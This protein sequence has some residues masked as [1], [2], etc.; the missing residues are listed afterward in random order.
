MLVGVVGVPFKERRQFY[1]NDT[2]GARL[3]FC[4]YDL[5]I[6]LL[7]QRDAALMARKKLTD[8]QWK[9]VGDRYALGESASLL[10]REFGVSEGAVRKRFS[11]RQKKIKSVVKQIVDAEISYQNLDFGTKSLVRN[12]TENMMK[13]SLNLSDA[14][15]SGSEV[16]KNLNAIALNLS[17][18]LMTQ[19]VEKPSLD[20]ESIKSI[21]S[22][23]LT[24]NQAAQ[25]G[26][27]L[28]KL[29]QKDIA[30]QEPDQP[31]HI[32]DAKEW[33]TE[34]VKQIQEKDIVAEQ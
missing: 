1:R 11:T 20:P 25:I 4:C 29:S 24:A 26:L 2:V 22:L 31:S 5:F 32:C 34:T 7:F 30:P 27:Q 12:I 33:L 15:I 19:D 13:T 18:S 23:H 28:L 8:E 14:S 16:A 6:V 9:K 10:G 21:A 3:G 17:R